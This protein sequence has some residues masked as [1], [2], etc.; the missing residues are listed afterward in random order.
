MPW[1]EVVSLE[2]RSVASVKTSDAFVLYTRNGQRLAGEPDSMSDD[3]LTWK[4][5]LLS[6]VQVPLEEVSSI[7]RAGA[8]MPPA[9]DKEDRVVL[10]NGDVLTGVIEKGDGGIVL[11]KGDGKYPGGLGCDSVV[12]AGADR[13]QGSAD[14]RACACDWRM[15]RCAW[16]SRSAWMASS[17]R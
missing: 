1:P 9:V 11:Q 5:S 16:Q 14:G 4:S 10:Q 15:G 12:I 7:G 3:K 13:R 17:C 2:Q 6:S 8:A